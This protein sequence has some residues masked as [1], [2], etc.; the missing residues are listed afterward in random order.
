MRFWLYE[1]GYCVHGSYAP[2][3]FFI[4]SNIPNDFIAINLKCLNSFKY[5][6]M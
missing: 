4:E 2:V 6:Y 3:D 1:I 5:L